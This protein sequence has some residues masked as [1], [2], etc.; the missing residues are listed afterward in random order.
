ML[1]L[2]KYEYQKLPMDNGPDIFQ[3]KMNKVF[4]G[5]DCVARTCIDNLLIISN[6]SFEDHIKRLNEV[7]RRLRSA[8]FKVNAKNIFWKGKN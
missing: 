5:L 8:V 3:E 1:P 7:L 4:N 6:K 2:G